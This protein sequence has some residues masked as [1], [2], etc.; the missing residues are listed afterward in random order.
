MED[1][2][3]KSFLFLGGLM[4]F[5]AFFWKENIGLNA[6][7]FSGLSAGFLAYNFPESRAEKSFWASVVGTLLVATMVMLHHSDFAIFAWFMSWLLMVGIG[8]LSGLH[9]VLYGFLQGFLN[10]LLAWTG[11][12]SKLS[13]R[14]ASPVVIEE[15]FVPEKT[16]GLR[17]ALFA[18]PALIVGS[19]VVL[20]A[21]GNQDFAQAVGDFLT[22]IF[23][24]LDWLK[25]LFSLRWLFFIGMGIFPISALIWSN[26]GDSFLK[27]QEKKRY[28]IAAPE[29]TPTM[30]KINDQ[31][32]TA[33]LTLAML[34]ILILFFNV[35]EFFNI[36]NQVA[37]ATATAMRYSVHFGT[38]ILVFSIVLAMGLLFY[39]FSDDLNFIEKS[40]TLRL[41]AYA[42][43]AQNAV[44][45]ITVA[46]RNYA[47][48]NN[49]GLAYKRVGVIF[50]LL[51]T[52]FGLFTMLLK[53][54]DIRTFSSILMLNG[55][56][57][58][59]TMILI[60]TVNWDVFI[61]RYNL[62]HTDP[63][64]LDLRFLLQDVSDKN[65]H[66]LLE[67]KSQLPNKSYTESR[68]WGLV[69]EEFNVEQ[70]LEAKRNSFLARTAEK[71]GFMSWNWI[72]EVNQRAA[73]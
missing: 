53:I 7:L 37:D 38:Y 60:S 9:D 51:L 25:D 61:T 29:L 6:L 70:M 1:K 64:R 46:L 40:P 73:K 44:M 2:Q 17:P 23:S 63:S 8:T 36:G 56:S 21:I 31:Y 16:G 35:Q 66:V 13:W 4:T 12:S 47:Y 41:L 59:L 39:F 62:T 34:N 52:L 15:E 5:H 71:G 55:W 54:K 45:V 57:V 28:F 65:L 10:T 18:V 48:I 26:Y 32:W 69:T 58:Y 11:L 49:Y 68:W 14:T 20:Y 3:I 72:D 27:M 33:F 67:Y 19:F 50:F 43:I 42:W 22:K 30:Q 24:S